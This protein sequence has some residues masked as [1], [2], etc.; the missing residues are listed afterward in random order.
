M[1]SSKITVFFSNDYEKKN[2]LMSMISSHNDVIAHYTFVID[3]ISSEISN[4][5]LESS[6]AP[7]LEFLKAMRAE[8]EQGRDQIQ[9][10][11]DELNQS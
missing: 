4:P 11:L 5:E 7:A 1:G 3:D 10:N 8:W 9:S 6:K 2:F